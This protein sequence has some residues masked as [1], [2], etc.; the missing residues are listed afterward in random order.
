MTARRERG[1]VTNAAGVADMIGGYSEAWFYGHRKRL[2]A[3]GFPK[4]D[5]LLG[6]WHKAA[7]EAWLARRSGVVPQS[8]PKRWNVQKALGEGQGP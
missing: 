4:R 3:D 7:V 2:E 1:Q 5:D 8:Q 6:G